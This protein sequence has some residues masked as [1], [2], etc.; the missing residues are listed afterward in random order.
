MS[1][2]RRALG[3]SA[4]I[5]VPVVVGA[6]V[7]VPMA[8]SGA[9]D[10]PEKT[11]AELIRFAEASEVDALSGTVEQTSD[12]GL[13]D[14]GALTGALGAPDGSA[15]GAPTAADLDDLLELA[16]GSHTAKVYV[17]GAN[18]RVQVLDRLA[19]RNVYVD[20]DAGTAWFVDSETQTATKL[21]LPAGGAEDGS[22]S[23]GPA[24]TPDAMLDDA[25]AS[26]DETTDVTVGDDARVAG[27]DVYELVLTPRSDDTLVGEVR[28]AID[29]E[30]GVALA[31]SVTARGSADPAFQVSFTQIDLSA[32]DPSVFA[33]TPGEGFT[34]VEK[35]AAQPHDGDRTASPADAAPV[36]TGTG[37]SSVI[38][39]P[40]SSES[41]ADVFGGLDPEQAALLEGITTR[42]DGGR[43]LETALLSVLLTDDGRVLAGA[44][45]PA[46]LVEAAQAGR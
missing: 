25:L 40:N 1:I 11:P 29:G 41:G 38:E 37:W 35:D 44:V 2:S 23:A 9:V 28:F 30:T 24:P 22:D 18:A 19:E 8:A 45:P 14:L 10:L 33:F 39:L 26:L 31:A 15:E 34:V 27:R 20:G 36:V 43:V 32:P 4:A 42:V 5:A 17:D 12:L 21:V 16:T 3:W 13:P 7:L 46:A 6:A